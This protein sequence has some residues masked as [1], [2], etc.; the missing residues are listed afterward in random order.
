MDITV[1][2]ID[3]LLI[4]SLNGTDDGID[5]ETFNEIMREKTSGG[6]R[7]III[8]CGCGLSSCTKQTILH[9]ARVRYE[10]GNLVAFVGGKENA[11]LGGG[12]ELHAPMLP[13]FAALR[14]AATYCQS[15]E[16]R[17]QAEREAGIAGFLDVLAKMLNGN[18]D[19]LLEEG[20]TN[21][22]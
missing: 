21:D 13:F 17:S 16:E 1:A 8:D 4:V 15:M 6:Y 5:Q 7:N 20:R 11:S 2:E 22:A 14:D 19:I 12:T 3:G 18:G 9:F 10:T